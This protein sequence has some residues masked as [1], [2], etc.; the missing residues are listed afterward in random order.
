MTVTFPGLART[1][2]AEG[3]Q[4]HQLVV[5][6]DCKKLNYITILGEWADNWPFAGGDVGVR[7]F[8]EFVA[9][10]PCAT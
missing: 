5:A 2:T 7:M 3:L 4:R 8:P 6:V 10:E 1:H 9:W